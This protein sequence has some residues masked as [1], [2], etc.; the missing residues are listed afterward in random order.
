MEDEGKMGD[1]TRDGLEREL[2]LYRADMYETAGSVFLRE[3]SDEEL[4]S[5]IE[6]ALAA[7]SDDVVR[8]SEAIVLD[9]L[10]GYEGSDASELGTRVRTEY[11]E[12]FIGPR[13]PLASPFES[14]YIGFPNRLFTDVTSQVRRAY[15]AMGI[16]VEKRNKVPDDHIGYE[17]MFLSE[18]CRREAAAIDTGDD[19]LLRGLRM[20]ERSFL[21]A[22]VNRWAGL[23][24]ERIEQA[25]CGDYYLAWARFVEEFAKEDQDFLESLSAV[26]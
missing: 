1:S 24:A 7:G 5:S 2:A 14:I 9:K 23:L 17:M 15:A 10:R 6:A 26:C 13:P 8:A 25:Y 21:A 19:N 3:P 20:A 22:H 18:L 12:L 16:A 4:S 11:A